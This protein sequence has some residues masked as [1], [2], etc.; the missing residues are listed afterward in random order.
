M[1]IREIELKTEIYNKYSEYERTDIFAL[2]E[3]CRGMYSFKTDYEYLEQALELFN[4]GDYVYYDGLHSYKEL[5]EM[6]VDEGLFGDIPEHLER[7][8][9][10]DAMANDLKFDYEKLSTGIIRVG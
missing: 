8:I 5:A 10:Y 9:D 3:Y 2:T 1:D 4:Q 7:Y 6:F